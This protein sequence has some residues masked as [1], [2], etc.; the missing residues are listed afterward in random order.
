MKTIIKIAI[1]IILAY[2][3]ITNW[4]T[5][6]PITT[7]ATILAGFSIIDFLRENAALLL[8]I[9]GLFVA[10]FIA[11]KKSKKGEEVND[12]GKND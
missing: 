12:N 9:I 7:G 8:V 5:I 4:T 6:I 3:I 10:A 1:A 11:G 2:L